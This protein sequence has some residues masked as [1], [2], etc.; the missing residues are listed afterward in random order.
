MPP[1]KNW[2][3]DPHKSWHDK[4]KPTTWRGRFV[5]RKVSVYRANSSLGPWAMEARGM[6]REGEVNYRGM[7]YRRYFD[8]KKEAVDYAITFMRRNE[9]G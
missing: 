2:E 5:S 6:T 7:E 8:T 9:D 3:K 4:D 1:I